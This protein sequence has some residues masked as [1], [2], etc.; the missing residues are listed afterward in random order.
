[1]MLATP[2]FVPRAARMGP[3]GQAGRYRLGQ[4]NDSVIRDVARNL[5]TVAEPRVRAIVADER[6]RLAEAVKA[7]LPFAGFSAVSFLTTQYFI[8]EDADKARIAGYMASAVALAA[9]V[10]WTASQLADSAALQQPVQAT[11]GAAGLVSQLTSGVAT[12]MAQAVVV[13]AEPKIRQI[14]DDE[15]TRLATAIQAGVP[16]AAGSAIA[17][18]ATAF[19]VP[20]DSPLAKVGGYSVSAILGG[21]AIWIAMNKTTEATVTPAQPAASVA[22]KA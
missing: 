9:G 2:K 1:M 13:E 20:E 18:A 15:K 11:G 5:V 7:G 4:V 21:L 10:W 8:P 16:W 12:Q 3:M 14:V 17:A 22:P 19:L 6:T